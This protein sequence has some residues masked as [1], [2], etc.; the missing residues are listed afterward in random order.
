MF[1]WEEYSSNTGHVRHVPDGERER[2]SFLRMALG[3]SYVPC[4]AVE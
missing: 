1:V 2:E 4:I 3:Y